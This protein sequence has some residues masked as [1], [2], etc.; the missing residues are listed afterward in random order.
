MHGC[1]AFGNAPQRQ[2]AMDRPS[3]PFAALDIFGGASMSVCVFRTISF[4]IFRT[5]VLRGWPA[6]ALICCIGIAAA[7][8]QLPEVVVRAAKPKPN[9]SRQP[10]LVPRRRGQRVQRRCGQRPSSRL[11]S[12]SR[13]GRLP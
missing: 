5:W 9:Q 10:T 7:Q 6:L 1:F 2:A 3:G 12:S 8:V 11:Q 4:P 13:P